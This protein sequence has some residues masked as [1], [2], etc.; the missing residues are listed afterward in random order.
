MSYNLA[1]ALPG[2]ENRRF[3]TEITFGDPRFRSA[4]YYR[5]DRVNTHWIDDFKISK[6]PAPNAVTADP[7]A[8]LNPVGDLNSTDS[9][10]KALGAAQATGTPEQMERLRA[11]LTEEDNLVKVNAAA[12]LGRIKDAGSVPALVAAARS[13]RVPYPAIMMVRAL[14]FQDAPEGWAVMKEIV[15]PG[16]SRGVVHRDGCKPDGAKT[17]SGVHRRSLDPYHR[18]PMVHKGCRRARLGRS[19]HRSRLTHATDILA[20]GRSDG[21][22]GGCSNRTP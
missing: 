4:N 3:V 16:P 14:G 9:Y 15:P 19:R 17:G 12:A 2:S 6:E 5:S 1:A 13:E 10:L 20:R 8:E 7:D 11:M 22:N 18:T 21:T